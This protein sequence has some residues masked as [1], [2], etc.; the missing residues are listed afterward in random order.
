LWGFYELQG[1][2]PV[3]C[4]IGAGIGEHSIGWKNRFTYAIKQD[5]TDRVYFVWAQTAAGI[6]SWNDLNRS[7][8]GRRLDQ[9]P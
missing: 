3:G 4:L 9:R 1:G 6:D 7:F 8:L 2:T 5:F